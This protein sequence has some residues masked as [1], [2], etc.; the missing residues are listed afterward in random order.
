MLIAPSDAA[1]MIT[2]SAQPN[3]KAVSR[4][5]ASRMNTYIPPVWGYAPDSSASV[6]APHSA[7]SPPA[8]HTDMSG[9]VRGAGW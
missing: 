2:S 7:K 4:P 8:I 5:H 6:S 9:A 1:R 3:R